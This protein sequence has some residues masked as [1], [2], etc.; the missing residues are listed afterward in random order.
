MEIKLFEIGK[1]QK[2]HNCACRVSR[3]Q[4][5]HISTA[6]LGKNLKTNHLF[7]QTHSLILCFH[8]TTLHIQ[9]KAYLICAFM[10]CKHMPPCAPACVLW[11]FVERKIHYS[12]MFYF[13]TGSFQAILQ[14]LPR[15]SLAEYTLWYQFKDTHLKVV[16]K[17]IRAA[18]S[19]FYHTN[20][21]HCSGWF[22]WT[23]LFIYSRRVSQWKSFNAAAT[24][25]YFSYILVLCSS[26]SVERYCYIKTSN[27]PWPQSDYYQRYS[28]RQGAVSLNTCTLVILYIIHH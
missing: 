4:L 3:L 21:G 6:K 19:I 14:K 27:P 22:L 17:L 20:M 2:Q 28:F 10:P 25:I 7:S 12:S 13:P 23:C 9:E 16:W 11:I 26:V 8:F 1:H 5:N 24:S 18:Y 15:I